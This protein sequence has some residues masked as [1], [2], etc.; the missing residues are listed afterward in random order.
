MLTRVRIRMDLDEKAAAALRDALDPDNVDF[1]DGLTLRMDVDGSNITIKVDGDNISQ[2][3]GTVDEVL[4]HAQIA[5]EVV[6][7]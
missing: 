6:G 1:P 4:A 5:L 7:C 3:I 2:V